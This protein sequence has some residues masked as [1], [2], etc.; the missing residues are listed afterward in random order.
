MGSWLTADE[1]RDTL[2]KAHE[3]AWERKIADEWKTLADRFKRLG[4][5]EYT[6]EDI[7]N[8]D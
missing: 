4:Q 5:R 3:K 8:A 2:E 6:E 7:K 1:L